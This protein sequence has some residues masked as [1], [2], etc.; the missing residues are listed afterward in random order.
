[1]PISPYDRLAV[2]RQICGEFLSQVSILPRHT[3]DQVKLRLTF[4]DGSRL[5][6]TETWVEGELEVYSYYW[7]DAE[8]NL[9]IGWDNAPHHT[10]IGT[11]PHH[12]HVGDRSNRQ[13]SEEH[14]L[15]NVLRAIV[16]RLG[17]QK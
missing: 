15:E 5:Y 17:S 3:H 11:F 12:K 1:M 9:I 6:V 10:Q 8:D 2:A 7:V 14:C 4:V 13:P 16:S